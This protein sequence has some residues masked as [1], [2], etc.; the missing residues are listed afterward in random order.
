MNGS[1]VFNTRYDIDT[2]A[3]I[4]D[5]KINSKGVDPYGEVTEGNLIIQAPMQ[6]LSLCLKNRDP[7]RS[8][9]NSDNYLLLRSTS[10]NMEVYK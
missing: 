8:N 4:P 9:A 2:L 3:E 7:E 1:P 6:R 10:T 5:F